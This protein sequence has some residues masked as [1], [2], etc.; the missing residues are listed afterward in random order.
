MY[1]LYNQGMLRCHV[2]EMLAA[3]RTLYV[4][5]KCVCAN[6]LFMTQLGPDMAM[7]ICL[8]LA[9]YCLNLPWLHAGPEQ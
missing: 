3:C 8:K 6:V 4:L 9:V 5:C 7:S 2:C 1:M